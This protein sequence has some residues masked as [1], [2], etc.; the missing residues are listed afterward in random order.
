M[1]ARLSTRLLQ[2]NQ[3][4]LVQ[5]RGLIDN[6]AQFGPPKNAISTAVLFLKPRIS[7]FFPDIYTPVICYFAGIVGLWRG[8]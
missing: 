1:I 4:S 3:F 7:A 5:K 8:N 2:K 6:G